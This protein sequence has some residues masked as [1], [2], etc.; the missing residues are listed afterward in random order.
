MLREVMLK[1]LSGYVKWSGKDLAPISNFRAFFAARRANP[2][3]AFRP[4][5]W[6]A[7]SG[8]DEARTRD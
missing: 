5:N 2:R 1:P 6:I 4:V 7:I 3:A 8:P